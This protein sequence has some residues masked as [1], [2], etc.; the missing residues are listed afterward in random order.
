[1]TNTK[2]TLWRQAFES[3]SNH[4]WFPGHKG[5]RVRDLIG[6]IVFNSFR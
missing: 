1:M 3:P 2:P 5:G 4:A 6:M